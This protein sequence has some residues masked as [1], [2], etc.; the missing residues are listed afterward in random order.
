MKDLESREGSLTVERDLLTSRLAST[1]EEL[2]TTQE[3]LLRERASYSNMTAEWGNMTDKIE[4]LTIREVGRRK[5]ELV[6]I[7][8]AAGLRKV[9]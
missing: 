6:L 8:P 9:F 1:T 4:D 5:A 3:T 2:E 7:R